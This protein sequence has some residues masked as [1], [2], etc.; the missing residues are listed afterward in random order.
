MLLQRHKKKR[1]QEASKDVKSKEAV[2]QSTKA[3]SKAP[4]KPKKSE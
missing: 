2:S 4:K 1:A 3:A